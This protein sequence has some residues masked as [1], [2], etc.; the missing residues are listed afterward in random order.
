MALKENRRI[1]RDVKVDKEDVKVT[2][3]VK[4]VS[5][6]GKVISRLNHSATISYDG[7]AMNIPPRGTAKRIELN[8]LGALPKGTQFIGE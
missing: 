1:I 6:I 5:L 4:V 7:K 8:K 3:P 2:Q